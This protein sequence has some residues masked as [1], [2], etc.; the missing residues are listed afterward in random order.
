MIVVSKRI[1]KN[2]FRKLK[3]Y[4]YF[5]K[6]EKIFLEKKNNNY[7]DDHKRKFRNILCN[8]QEG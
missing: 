2:F 7:P 5:K 4:N 1:F 3:I 8:K 6:I